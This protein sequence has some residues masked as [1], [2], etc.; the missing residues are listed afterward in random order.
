MTVE[1]YTIEHTGT[2]FVL[3][4]LDRAG[5]GKMGRPKRNLEPGRPDLGTAF[6]QRKN[7]DLSLPLRCHCSIHLPKEGTDPRY[8]NGWEEP[9]SN[10][11]LVVTVRHPHDVYRSWSA[12]KNRQNLL[13][14]LVATWAHFLWRLQGREVF[15]FALDV[16][17]EEREFQIKE[18][19]EFC[20]IFKVPNWMH[21]YAKNWSRVG[22]STYLPSDV[23]PVT[24]HV[25][26][27]LL[28]AEE[29]YEHYTGA[30]GCEVPERGG[31]TK[32]DGTG[33][34]P[35]FGL[36]DSFTAEVGST[37]HQPTIKMETA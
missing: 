7:A 31:W 36:G 23:L 30:W 11:P 22:A 13:P 24:D 3:D 33:S 10:T 35:A 18:L 32:T 9:G 6:P 17:P 34:K 37:G 28:F 25:R 21:E 20:D 4:I 5:L 29:W 12:K 14:N 27:C 2:R 8:P 19:L 1:V 15:Y 16:P 26:A